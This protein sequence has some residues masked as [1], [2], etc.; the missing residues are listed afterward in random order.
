MK[1][2]NVVDWIAVVLLVVGGL[3]WGLF[4]LLEMDLVDMIFGGYNLA[5][6]VVYTLVG[7]AAIYMIYMAYEKMT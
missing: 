6:R 7:V 1:E 2:A 3:N 4:G 5:S